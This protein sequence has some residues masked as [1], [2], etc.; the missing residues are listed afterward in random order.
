M[1]KLTLGVLCFSLGVLANSFHIESSGRGRFGADDLTT[2]NTAEEVTEAQKIVE[3]GPWTTDHV[4]VM[5]LFGFK[6]PLAYFMTLEFPNGEKATGLIAGG[7]GD[8]AWDIVNF[9]ERYEFKRGPYGT[10]NYVRK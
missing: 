10:V 5:D 4:A 3:Q 6:L 7:K 2:Q 1:K 8:H 9:T